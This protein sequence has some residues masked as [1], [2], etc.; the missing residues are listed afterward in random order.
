MT[1]Y[2]KLAA[3]RDT[4]LFA[5][6]VDPDKHNPDSLSSLANHAEVCGVDFFLLGGSLIKRGMEETLIVLKASASIPVILFP[7]SV[8]QLCSG[9][10]GILLL[11]LISGRNPEFLIGNH[12]VAA[13]A[14]KNSGMEVI[15]TGYILIDT[16]KPTSVQYMS[17]TMPIPGNKSDIVVATAIAGEQ[18]GNKA[19]YLEGGSGAQGS[20]STEIIKDVKHSVDIPI[21]VGGGIRTPQQV[22][23]ARKAGA[24]MIVVGSAI[25]Q[26]LQLLQ[27]LVFASR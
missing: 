20:I 12:V 13:H 16:G 11:S 7:G 25:E 27:D 24:S 5:L 14:I 21:V 10:D 17:G 1:I 3:T 19:I 23:R 18:L 26:N 15:P 2:S 9:A 4:G 22:L 6:L 8:F